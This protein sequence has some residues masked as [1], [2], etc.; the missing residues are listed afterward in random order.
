MLIKRVSTRGRIL[1]DSHIYLGY[2]ILKTIF[3]WIDR[4]NKKSLNQDRDIGKNMAY[5]FYQLQTMK[6]VINNRRKKVDCMPHLNTGGDKL[7]VVIFAE[8]FKWKEINDKQM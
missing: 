5:L 7:R 6:M 3:S 1:S 8:H 4:H 2:E